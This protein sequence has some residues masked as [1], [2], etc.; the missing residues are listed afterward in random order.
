[1][2]HF[3][4][5]LAGA[6]ALALVGCGKKHEAKAPAAA[7]KPETA[8][9]QAA[10]VSAPADPAKS[11]SE[12]LAASEKFL[13]DNAKHDGVKTTASGLQYMVLSHGA[14]GGISPKA[15]D[16]VTVHYVGTLIDGQEFDSSRRR[17]VAARFPLNGVIPGWTEGLQLMKEGDR[18]RF[19]IPPGLAYGDQAQGPGGPNQALIFDVE[20]LK[21]SNP[22]RSKAESDKWLAD[23]AKKP[24]VKSTSSGLLY[25][26]VAKGKGDKNPAP[27]NVVRVVFKGALY[28]GTEVQGL[29]T[30]GE[31]VEF[32][33]AAI[34]LK[35]WVEGVELM[36]AG[37]KFRLY[38]PPKLAFGEHG[39]PDG[40]IGPNEAVQ[41][42][43]ELVDIKSD[44]A[45]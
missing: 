18:F 30:R 40:A 16:L 22:A 43:V 17:G 39:T 6:T 33:L 34:E 3:Y 23:I 41:F 4:L 8:V 42:D 2:K 35:G 1:M 7:A 37:D 11:A 5:A 44:K 14:A 25:E 36:R 13:A 20:L 38:M 27:E 28:D 31:T 9:E 15:T 21:V 12:N 45:P 29:D 10:A 19:F 26:V 24:G 32:P